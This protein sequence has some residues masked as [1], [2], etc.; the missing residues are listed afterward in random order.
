MPRFHGSIM[1]FGQNRLRALAHIAASWLQHKALARII[2]GPGLR[3]LR[4]RHGLRGDVEAFGTGM[5]QHASNGYKQTRQP[6]AA[7][8]AAHELYG[9]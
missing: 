8:A 1:W 9:G 3:H 6:N 4:K 7:H 5:G 2:H